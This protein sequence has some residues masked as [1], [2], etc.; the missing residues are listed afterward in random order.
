ML[1]SG[2]RV[3]GQKTTRFYGTSRP[4]VRRPQNDIDCA[5]FSDSSFLQMSG[6]FNHALQPDH[7]ELFAGAG[8]RIGTAY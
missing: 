7:P 8:S 5:L 2:F 3:F 6:Q 1:L 4:F